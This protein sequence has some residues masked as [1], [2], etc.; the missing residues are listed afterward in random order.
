MS[1]L[2]TD[3]SGLKSTLFALVDKGASGTVFVATEDNRASQVVL[4][5]GR[6]QGAACNGLYNVAAFDVLAAMAELR[7]SFTPELIY[8]VV[9][10]LL[11]VQGERLLQQLG[12]SHPRLE[13]EGFTLTP[14][15][16][17]NDCRRGKP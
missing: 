10:S 1:H 17:S 4:L 16:W 8:P 11:P 15:S 14:T 13:T 9:D 2:T 3:F 5:N 7:F 6:L 12:Y